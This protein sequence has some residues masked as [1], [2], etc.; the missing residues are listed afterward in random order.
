MSDLYF[1]GEAEKLIFALVELDGM[2]QNRQ[3]G[4]NRSH[5][6]SK[7]NAHRWLDKIASIIH[8]DTCNHPKAKQAFRELS[9]IYENMTGYGEGD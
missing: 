2:C 8:P 5:F 3:L 7:D 4:I 6:S 1:K 9:E